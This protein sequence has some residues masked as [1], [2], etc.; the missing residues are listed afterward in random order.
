MHDDPKNYWNRRIDK[1]DSIENTVLIDKNFNTV[2]I[3]FY[4]KSVE[5]LTESPL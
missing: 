1:T 2:Y 4:E 3:T 5:N